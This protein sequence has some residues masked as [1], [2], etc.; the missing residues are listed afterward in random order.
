MAE[1]GRDKKYFI[2]FDHI[3]EEDCIEIMKQILDEFLPQPLEHGCN[4]CC[5]C[6]P[7]Y[8][9]L[10]RGNRAVRHRRIC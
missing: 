1:I 9:A 10:E 6:C 8:L 3:E 5:Q 2:G 4:C 7:D